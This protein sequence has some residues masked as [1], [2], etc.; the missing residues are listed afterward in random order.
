[1]LVNNIYFCRKKRAAL[2][3]GEVL[4][5]GILGEEGAQLLPGRLG[6]NVGEI[7]LGELGTP[8]DLSRPP[9]RG[10]GPGGQK[11]NLSR[12]PQRGGGP[13]GQRGG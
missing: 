2:Q 1:M 5:S 10:G 8:V 6:L 7:H 4:K 9:R 11:C 13:T 12:P 3:S